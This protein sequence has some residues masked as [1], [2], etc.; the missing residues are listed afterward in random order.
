[1]TKTSSNKGFSSLVKSLMCDRVLAKDQG[2]LR[3]DEFWKKNYD[4]YEQDLYHFPDSINQ[5]GT[6]IEC[7]F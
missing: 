4:P 6:E 1:M 5:Y 7:F 2:T 3:E